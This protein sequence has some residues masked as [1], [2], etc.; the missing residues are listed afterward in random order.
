MDF[1]FREAEMASADFWSK[2]ELEQKH[3]KRFAAITYASY[4]PQGIIPDESFP[5]RRA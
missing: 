3:S 5:A 2:G 4:G 1:E